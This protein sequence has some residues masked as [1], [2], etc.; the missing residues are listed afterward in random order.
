MALELT[1]I[2]VIF[3]GGIF[4][5]FLY[6]LNSKTTLFESICTLKYLFTIVTLGYLVGMQSQV[7][8]RLVFSIFLVYLHLILA[9]VWTTTLNLS[10][11]KNKQKAP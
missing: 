6:K 9:L 7:N 1:L 2:G 3:F 5:H 4:L 10:F 8:F 11:I